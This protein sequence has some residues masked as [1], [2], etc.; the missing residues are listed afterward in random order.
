MPSFT[1]KSTLSSQCCRSDPPLPCQDAA[2]AHLDSLSSYDLVLW[3]ESSVPF[4]FS[5]GG[6]GVLANCSFCGTETTLSFS[7]GPVCSS[8]SVEACTILQ[9]LCWSRQHQQVCHFS[10]RPFVSDS[11]SLS[12]PSIL[13]PQSLC[14]IWQERSSLSSC[15]IRL[16]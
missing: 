14:Q 1:V 13:L 4:R 8:F 11:R 16:Q 15:S 9:A 5:K 2:L 10:S 3:T 12:P 6:S 7:T